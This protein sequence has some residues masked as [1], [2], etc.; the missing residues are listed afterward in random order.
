[1]FVDVSNEPTA[2]GLS[3]SYH[4]NISCLALNACVIVLMSLHRPRHSHA[5]TYVLWCPVVQRHDWA[6]WC[7]G[8]RFDLRFV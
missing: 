2:G 7:G 4:I 8:I 6:E 1:M 5:V 3:A